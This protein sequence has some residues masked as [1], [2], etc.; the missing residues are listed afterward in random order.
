MNSCQNWHI[1]IIMPCIHCTLKRADDL[2]VYYSPDSASLSG[3]SVYSAECRAGLTIRHGTH[4]RRAPG[5]KGAPEWYAAKIGS[6]SCLTCLCS[7][8]TCGIHQIL[9]PGPNILQRGPIRQSPNATCHK[10]L[11]ALRTIRGPPYRGDWLLQL[12]DEFLVLYACQPSKPEIFQL[13]W[14]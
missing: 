3:R 14:Q 2:A 9:G 10:V 8:A 4:V 7:V 11:N 12:A 13:C 5:W 6:E 1:Y